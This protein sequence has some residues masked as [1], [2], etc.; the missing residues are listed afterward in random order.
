[1]PTNPLYAFECGDTIARSAEANATL[2]V[3]R[4]GREIARYSH[5]MNYQMSCSADGKVYLQDYINYQNTY[6]IVDLAGDFPREP[7]GIVKGDVI[8]PD[9][10]HVYTVENRYEETPVRIPREPFEKYGEIRGAPIH[11]TCL[12][13]KHND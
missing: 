2:R 11:A 7:V 1:M 3:I 9:G 5:H 10:K 4:D 13:I 8:S 12:I 6:Y